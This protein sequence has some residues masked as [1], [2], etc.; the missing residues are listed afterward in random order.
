MKNI[1]FI[2]IGGTGDLA[3]RKLVPAFIKL[4]ERKIISKESTFIGIGRSELNDLSYKKLLKDFQT[5]SNLKKQINNLN[6]KFYQADS[7]KEGS[8]EGL[9]EL[10]SKSESKE[11][12]RV[13]YYS[14]SFKLF[15]KI[16]TEIKRAKL[17]KNKDGFTRI[18]FEKPFGEDLKSCTLF[19]NTLHEAYSEEQLFRVDHYLGKETVRNLTVLKYAN[20]FFNATLNNKLVENIKICVNEDLPIG[21]RAN[22]YNDFGAIKDMFQSHLLQVLSLL[23]MEPRDDANS[24]TIH[25]EKLKILQQ[26][27]V[28]PPKEQ[29]I[30]QYK[31]YSKELKEQNLDQKHTETYAK[32][33][34]NCNNERWNGVPIIIQTGKMLHEKAAKITISFKKPKFCSDKTPCDFEANKIILEI[35]PKQDINFSFNIFELGS[36]EIKSVEGNFCHDCEFGA[37]TADGY[38]NIFEDVIKGDQTRFST[39]EQI[40]ESWKITDKLLSKKDEIPFIIYDD[41]KTPE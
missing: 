9:N 29:L 2:V 13:F 15:S 21:K 16:T 34:L 3:K 38:E 11:S 23:L 6:I 17:N 10:L 30:G 37:N 28:M 27:E 36:K 22:Y 31:S 12:N 40:K 41:F 39:S 1:S 35:Q 32:I 18:A 7:T 26:I 19:E 5:D 8:L 4:I 24:K 20:P 33:K 14:T 25:T